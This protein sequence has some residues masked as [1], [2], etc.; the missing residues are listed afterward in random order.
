VVATLARVLLF[1]YIDTYHRRFGACDVVRKR[2]NANAQGR[3]W[4]CSAFSE[5]R[6]SFGE[7]L[8]N[9]QIKS[10]NTIAILTGSVLRR[11]GAEP[12]WQPEAEW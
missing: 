12:L 3:I 2:E 6:W 8:H 11:S 4:R 1:L 5:A 10:R 7:Q 9:L